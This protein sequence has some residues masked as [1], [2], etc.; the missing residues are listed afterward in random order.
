MN[1]YTDLGRDICEAV[2]ALVTT[3]DFGE[4]GEITIED[5]DLSV[6]VMPVGLGMAPDE[7]EN[8]KVKLQMVDGRAPEGAASC[9]LGYRVT[10]KVRAQLP[11]PE[12]GE[13][14]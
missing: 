12:R 2:S 10:P 1:C 7:L 8:D 6:E 14:I 4:I 5:R 9:A 11:A 13:T 3:A